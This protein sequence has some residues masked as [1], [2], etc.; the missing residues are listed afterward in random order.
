MF[1]HR[2]GFT[3]IEIVISLGV[4][5]VFIGVITPITLQVSNRADTTL[6]INMLEDIEKGMLWYYG[7]IGDFP[8]ET[9][10]LKSNIAIP[11]DLKK[12]GNPFGLAALIEEPVAGS[13]SQSGLPLSPY[14]PIVWNGP[15]V[16]GQLER[17]MRDAWGEPLVY[18]PN[19]TS[20]V[21]RSAYTATKSLIP[22]VEIS[23]ESINQEYAI[24][25][26]ELLRIIMDSVELDMQPQ[27]DYASQLVDPAAAID[28]LIQ[29]LDD[30][31]RNY[32]SSYYQKDP[33]GEPFR[34]HSEMLQFYSLGPNRKRDGEPD[35]TGTCNYTHRICN[36]TLGL[37]GTL[38]DDID[39]F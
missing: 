3:L 15:Y 27:L 20:I 19:N 2:G 16:S 22:S 14:E 35:D 5:S 7:D 34:W 21:I 8:P 11:D 29:S 10:V 23:K 12:G 32:L 24:R 28:V 13:L 17:M 1:R 39:G 36:G 30:Q 26:N 25:V 9:V 37:D 33:W 18:E 6:T 4:L 31:G 38:A